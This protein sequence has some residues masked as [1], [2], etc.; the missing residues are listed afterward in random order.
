MD[1]KNVEIDILIPYI[2]NPRKNDDAVDYVASSIKEFGFKQPIVL[3]KE[4]VIVVGHTRYLAAKKLGLTEVPV[5]YATELSPAQIKAYRI[6]DNKTND[7]SD[8]DNS[9]LIVELEQIQ[10]LNYDMN[11]TAFRMSE[12]N[13]ISDQL[14]RWTN[15]SDP[16]AP[17]S[18]QQ[19]NIKKGD[20]FQLGLH[21]VMCGD[22]TDENH[23][24]Q[25]MNNEMADLL[26]TDPPYNIDYV[27]L[28]KSASSEASVV[29][30]NDK[31][32]DEDY[33]FFLFSIFKNINMFTKPGSA[34]YVY[35]GHVYYNSDLTVRKALV[36]A[37]YEVKQTLIWLKDNPIIS[38]QDYNYQTE[39]MV[40][41]FKPAMSMDYEEEGRKIYCGWKGGKAHR[42]YGGNKQSNVLNGKVVRGSGHTTSK[43]IEVAIKM[44]ENSTIYND[45]VVD[46]FGGSGST[47][48]AAEACNRRCYTMELNPAYV[49]LIIDRFNSEFQGRY[50]EVK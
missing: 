1:V 4:N 18:D 25:L 21:R 10:E 35:Y 44:M 30:L 7:Y 2:N 22:A 16:R 37:G 19:T 33:Y 28:T 31:M 41:G 26:L 40:Y 34:C 47:L 15:K 14:S 3:D 38:R 12:L 46:L 42:W 13:Q 29:L 36:D 27:P 45:I 8:W 11:L 43:P 50:K 24:R 6:A 32:S 5:V 23:V 9:K 48:L 20:I 39:E 49:Q 17:Q